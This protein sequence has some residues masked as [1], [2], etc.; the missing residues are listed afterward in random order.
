MDIVQGLMHMSSTTL[1][2]TKN[3]SML[4]PHK[5][6]WDMVIYHEWVL[7]VNPNFAHGL[8]ILVRC[9]LKTLQLKY[10][11]LEKTIVAH[12]MNILCEVLNSHK[13]RDLGFA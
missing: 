12:V 3:L 10:K 8:K 1:E 11:P 6:S 2:G 4:T 13:R 5:M 9:S 7:I